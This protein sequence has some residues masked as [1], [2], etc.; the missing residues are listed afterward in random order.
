MSRF[1]LSICTL[2]L[3]SAFQLGACSDSDSHRSGGDGSEDSDDS[4]LP[5][6]TDDTD[7]TDETE[8]DSGVDTSDDGTDTGNAD[9]CSTLDILFIVDDSASMSEEQENLATN[10]P[11]FI[12]VLDGYETP[13]G[14][15]VSYRIGVTTIGVTR[16]FK[17]NGTTASTTDMG[18]EVD[19]GVL[20]GLDTPPT[21][22]CG[23]TEPWINGPGTQVVDDF[24]CAATVGLEGTFTEMPFAVIESALGEQ[25]APGGPN[26]G[27]YRKDGDSLLVVVIITDEDDCS[28]EEGGKMI[29]TAKGASDCGSSTGIYPPADTKTFLDNLAGPERYVVIGMAAHQQCTSEFGKADPA[30]RIGELLE[31]C[32]D[33]DVFTDICDG[34]LW[35]GLQDGLDAI[36]M[37]CDDMPRPV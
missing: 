10:F 11:Q 36:K 27:F 35:I 12:E 26:E 20:L 16:S 15:M 31:L 30:T 32:G 37:A 34:D 29:A 33:Y 24:N 22:N 14:T 19:D 28:I 25:A 7:D 23:F 13:V 5:G 2:A 9:G 4:G 21:P 1:Y 17:Q 3:L 8:D 18:V 6:D